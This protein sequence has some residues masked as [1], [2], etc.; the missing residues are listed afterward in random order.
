MCLVQIFKDP[1]RVVPDNQHL[2]PWHLKSI[3]KIRLLGFNL[4]KLDYQLL[5]SIQGLYDLHTRS[6]ATDL[7]AWFLV[8]SYTQ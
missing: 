3:K 7:L 2:N 1:F 6:L 8:N 4:K 5:S